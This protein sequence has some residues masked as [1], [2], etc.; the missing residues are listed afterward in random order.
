[1]QL[2]WIMI[3]AAVPILEQKVAI[4][5]AMALGYSDATAFFITLLGALIPA[6]FIILFLPK[7]FEFMRRFKYLEPLV[8]WYEK[9]AMRRGKNIVKYELLGLLMFVAIPL[10]MTGVWTGSAVAA[11]L[12]LDFKKAFPTVVLGAAICGL[13]LLFVFKGAFSLPWLHLNQ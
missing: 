5:T 8:D 9:N 1:M 3:L 6:P 13:I 4:P 10:P 7:V 11:F 12:K 2:L